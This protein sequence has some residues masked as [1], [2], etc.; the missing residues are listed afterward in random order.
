MT[1]TSLSFVVRRALTCII[2]HRTRQTCFIVFCKQDSTWVT[3]AFEDSSCL[4]EIYLSFSRI[5]QS[6]SPEIILVCL[7]STEKFDATNKDHVQRALQVRMNVPLRDHQKSRN[8]E[9]HDL[10]LRTIVFSPVW[11]DARPC[12]KPT[13]WRSRT[14]TPLTTQ[15]A[16]ETRQLQQ[17]TV[18]TSRWLS[19]KI[20][21]DMSKSMTFLFIL[22]SFLNTRANPQCSNLWRELQ[23]EISFLQMY[24][25]TDLASPPRWCLLLQLQD[26]ESMPDIAE[27][28]SAL[29][30]KEFSSDG[31][32]LIFDRQVIPSLSMLHP[33]V[34]QIFGLWQACLQN[35]NP[36]VKLFHAPSV[37][38]T[39]LEIIT[40]LEN[41][42]KNTETLMFVIYLSSIVSMND[43]DCKSLMSESKPS[44][45]AKFSNLTQRALI[46]AEFSPI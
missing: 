24:A 41:I 31:E 27:D 14:I 46:N 39:L 3:N 38:Q 26:V 25:V 9:M 4:W 33:S 36:L 44:L 32:S 12:F 5:C 11:S 15:T 35:V 22:S 13:V 17:Q 16:H 6:K 19:N 43:H 20:S 30:T 29:L 37:Q 7:V 21:H 1:I 18:M 28:D 42:S 8:D 2:L 34:P 23:N 40:D 10:I 45:L